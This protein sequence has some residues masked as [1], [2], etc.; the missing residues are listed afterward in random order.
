[1]NGMKWVLVFVA[2][3][4]MGASSAPS[5]AVA[6]DGIWRAQDALE[7]A[8]VGIYAP[9]PVVIECEKRATPTYVAPKLILCRKDYASV[10]ER[11]ICEPAK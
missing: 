9:K 1:M 4:A 7:R 6:A 10:G 3:L 8:G 2:A 5:L 11:W